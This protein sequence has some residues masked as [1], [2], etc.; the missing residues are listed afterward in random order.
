MPDTVIKYIADPANPFPRILA[1]KWRPFGFSLHTATDSPDDGSVWILFTPYYC[2]NRYMAIEQYCFKHLKKHYPQAKFIIIGNV[3]AHHT[4]Y[5]DLFD[6]PESPEKLIT[7]ALTLSDE[8]TPVSSKAFNIMEKLQR[9]VDGHSK[10]STPD[11]SVRE[12]L[13]RVRKGLGVN[14]DALNDG[15]APEEV[16]ERVFKNDSIRNFSAIESRWISYYPFF[17]CLPFC[18]IFVEIDREISKIRDAFQN[19]PELFRLDDWLE[20]VKAIADHIEK[21]L[22]VIEQ[23]VRN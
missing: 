12:A 8:W 3:A 7:E 1:E 23:Y 18:T 20:Q 4:N 13:S 17:E 11:Q 9:F 6:L 15:D 22:I 19:P 14:R 2:N 10:G 21:L 5:C 16:F